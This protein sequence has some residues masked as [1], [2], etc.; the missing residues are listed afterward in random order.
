MPRNLKMREAK[1]SKQIQ[2][3]GDSSLNIQAEQITVGLSYD[4]FKA[5]AQDVFD[6]N[7]YKL[8]G[9]ASETAKD[10]ADKIVNQF[11]TELK[12]KNPEGLNIAQDPDFQYSLYNVQKEYARTG[13]KDLGDI[14]VD[15]LVDRTKET[16]R[17]I[18]QIVLNEC[19]ETAPK[20]T[21]H[22]YSALSVIFIFKYTKYRRMI[23]L[24]EFTKYINHV[25]SPFVPSLL[26]SATCYQ[27][28]AY[29]GCGTIG[30]GSASIENILLK[31]YPGLFVKGFRQENISHLLDE[32]PKLSQ[33]ISP[34]LRDPNLLQISAVDE[35][36]IRE[37]ASPLGIE[38]S[39]IDKL[40]QVQK[41]H[42]MNDKEVKD[43]SISAHTCMKDLY[44]VWDNSY[45]KNLTLTSVGIA[46]GHANIRRVTGDEFDLSIWINE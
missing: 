17:N 10:R 18:K 26:K 33:I 16:N 30:I 22:Q 40:I 42:M 27:H 41:N 28:L 24:D 9:I 32:E 11:L 35:S 12:E 29:A 21:K 43:Y 2:K 34:C 23:S 19:L 36:T 39:T 25:I 44:D 6:A 8:S 15:I 1:K 20:L 46:I 38:S 31:R 3:S 7:F 4:E 13:D 14:L 45:M 37:I 5:I